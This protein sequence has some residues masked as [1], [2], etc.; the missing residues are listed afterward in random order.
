MCVCVCVCVFLMYL[1]LKN[2]F[3]VLVV[4]FFRRNLWIS[5]EERGSRRKSLA[6]LGMIHAKF[7]EWMV[8]TRMSFLLSFFPFLLMLIET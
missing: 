8:S 2:N 1:Y 7:G 6:R 3:F 5:V 4:R